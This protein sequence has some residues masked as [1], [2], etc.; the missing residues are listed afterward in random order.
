MGGLFALI[1]ELCPVDLK[2]QLQTLCALTAHEFPLLAS[3]HTR[4]AQAPHG[5]TRGN[6]FLLAIGMTQYHQKLG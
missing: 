3:G 6:G 1:R 4:F 2:H 5:S